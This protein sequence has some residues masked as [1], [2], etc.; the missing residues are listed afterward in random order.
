MAYELVFSSTERSNLNSTLITR[1]NIFNEI[2]IEI[3]NEGY[4]PS[5]ICLDKETAIRLAKELRKQI[6]FLE[7]E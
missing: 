3:N 1:V 4:P 7:G 6:S 5:F 2:F